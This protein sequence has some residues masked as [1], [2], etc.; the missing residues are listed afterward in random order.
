MVRSVRTRLTLWYTSLLTV[1]LLLVGGAAY[2]LLSYSLSREMDTALHSVAGA[3]VEQAHGRSR[4]FPQSEIDELFR[5]FFGFSP[6]DPYFQM[7][8]PAGNRQDQQSSSR[9]LPL[10]RE[11]FDNA[12]HG[13]PSFETVRG[14]DEYPVRVLTMPVIEG[15][16]V[17]NI[18]QVGMTLK[19]LYETRF[20]F[21]LIMAGLLPFGMILAG[22]GGW[23]LAHRAL[24]PVGAMTEAARKI[25]SERLDQRLKETGTGDELDNLA[26]T[27]NRMLSRLDDGFRQVRQF[28]ADVSH[29][30]QTPLTIL[31][32][33]LEVALRSPR[34]PAEYQETL[35]SAL[36]EVDR[37]A[38]LVEGLLLLARAEAGMLRMD[39]R[40]VDLA[41][42]LETVHRQLK[43]IADS[44]GVE[45]RL[46]S[47]EHVA[48]QGD[49]ERLQS[50][51]SNLADN[52][53]K[54][55]RPGGTVTLS[56]KDEGNMAAVV[57]SDTG[58]GIPAEER[59]R[60]F[61]TFYR[62]PEGRAMAENGT[63][64]G[65]AIAMSI[66]VA[67]HGTIRVESSPES[68]S[69]FTASIPVA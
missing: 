50:M 42:I 17:V 2:G 18:V 60:I 22:T 30:L 63:G 14:L 4:A 3:M 20:R 58:I 21:L 68:G 62:A 16:R 52:A 33:E 64:L 6:W 53:I 35:K 10:S 29:E 59:E 38:R 26:R 45:L 39:R 47:P 55:T 37:I 48:I 15:N 43:P 61:Q 12:L 11:A 23:A 51:V 19:S 65:L 24:K 57:V 49:R 40:E 56:L 66:A 8:D 54:Y 25:S 44:H 46:E 31:K 67:H 5:R 34:T 9:K 41:V 69:T 28:S 36:E 13:I 7:R 27:L 1:T 32:G